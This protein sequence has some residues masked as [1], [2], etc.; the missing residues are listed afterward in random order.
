L[1]VVQ[2]II[3]NIDIAPTLAD[4]AGMLDGSETNMDGQ[5]FKSL[6]T[7]PSMK[8]ITNWRTK[9]LVEHDGEVKDVIEGC[10]ALNHQHVAVSL[11]LVGFLVELHVF[12]HTGHGFDSCS[13]FI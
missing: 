9:F 7:Y 12:M 1:S 10:P 6:L 5:S 2:E 8:P 4:L 11:E 3:L 13:T